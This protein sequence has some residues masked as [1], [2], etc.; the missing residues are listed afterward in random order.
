[1]LDQA[2][3]TRAAARSHCAPVLLAFALATGG[4]AADAQTDYYN[5][6]RGRPLRVED[7]LPIERHAIEWQLAP[8]RLSGARGAGSTLS[9]EPEL[10]WGVWPRTQV[11]VGVPLALLRHGGR[12]TIGGA[13]ID[14]AVL[15]AFNTETTSLPAL[16]ASVRMVVP[17]GPLGPSRSVATFT[18]L[19]TRTLSSGRIHL[20]LSGSPGRF[21]ADD[22]VGEA[23]RW[24]AGVALDHAFVFRALLLGADLVARSPLAGDAGVAW[25][26]ATGVRYQ[27]GPRL[28]VDAG[29]GR[30]FDTDG[31]WFVTFGSA[32]SVAL[33]HRVGGVR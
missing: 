13:G 16:A 4:R 29:I 9:A 1:M 19:A 14:L 21:R 25:S 18:A 32:V 28:G 15:H 10:A 20:N 27:V 3:L 7:A 33:L 5:L 24:A 17:A 11:E 8:L 2:L 26:A 22:R 30:A 23:A 6:D 12:E 31:E